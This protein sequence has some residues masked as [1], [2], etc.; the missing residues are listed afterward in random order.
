MYCPMY[1]WN[2][3]NPDDYPDKVKVEVI[4]ENLNTSANVNYSESL[5]SWGK[6]GT[7]DLGDS[8]QIE[9]TLSA[10]EE[11]TPLIA[12]AF[13]LVPVKEY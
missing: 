7:F 1:N 8:D 6:I 2:S 12:D 5:N 3:K 4:N 13:M 10:I 11:N 9:F